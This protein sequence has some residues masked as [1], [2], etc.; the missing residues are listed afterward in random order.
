MKKCD[1]LEDKLKSR[2]K[3]TLTKK[4]NILRTIRS[5][6]KIN[7]C[8][9]YDNINSLIKNR[10]LKNSLEKDNKINLLDFE[11]NLKKNQIEKDKEMNN[12]IKNIIPEINEK[13]LKDKIKKN[14]LDTKME[15]NLKLDTNKILL[16]PNINNKIKDIF[17]KKIK[18]E[19]NDN[20]EENIDLNLEDSDY[21]KSSNAKK[22]KEWKSWSLSEKEL[23]YEA[24]ANG[25][26]YSSLQKLFK[27]MND[28]NFLR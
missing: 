16:P 26:N 15:N 5:P 14:C 19:D 10:I 3:S 1:S 7:Q 25:A 24:I 28:V 27:N 17:I 21:L 8:G 4:Q 18:N 20:Y 22:K 13:N 11:N 12:I 23:F 9:Q 2:S 6:L